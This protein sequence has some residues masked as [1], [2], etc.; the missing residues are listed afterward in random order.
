MTTGGASVRGGGDAV[1]FLLGSGRCGSSV[2][3]ELVCRHPDVAFV[4]NLED[5][6]SGMR[7]VAGWNGAVY[8]ALPD[9]WTRKGR[10]RFAPSEAY[11]A[12]ERDVSPLLSEPCRDPRVV[13]ATDALDRRLRAFFLDRPRPAGSTLVHKFTGW[14]R[15]ALLH[16]AFPSAR[17]VHIVRD[18]RAVVN[19]WL[20]MPWWRGHLG[21]EGWHFGPLPAEY[22]LEW[23][24]YDHSLVVLA[25]LGWKMVL[26]AHEEAEK[27]VGP[28][29]WLTLR[30][31]DFAHD[32]H[33]TMAQ[34]LDFLELRPDP[35][36]TARVDTLRVDDSRRRAFA[37]DLGPEMTAMLTRA[38]ADHLERYGY[39]P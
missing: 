29:A 19:S 32:P 36:F 35:A 3:H 5:K 16:R 27:L 7:R 18:G 31:E 11:R 8:R 13:D 24:E 30:Y 26:D 38:L 12:L 1:H 17:Y 33:A 28:E 10:L 20:Q 6:R 37:D 15:V 9:S 4:S 25:G 2:I 23:A 34:L 14:P 22:E 39:A 21:P